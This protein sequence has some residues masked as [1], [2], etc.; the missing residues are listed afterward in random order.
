[1]Q[2]TERRAARNDLGVVKIETEREARPCCKFMTLSCR[3][4]MVREH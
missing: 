1:M 2:A 4:E 3:A